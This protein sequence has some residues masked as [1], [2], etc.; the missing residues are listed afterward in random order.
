MGLKQGFNRLEKGFSRK[1]TKSE[2]ARG[3]L[4]VSNDTIV[5]GM[6]LKITINK[7]PVKKKRLDSYGR[8]GVGR[9]LMRQFGHKKVHFR[10]RD[11][12]IE[13]TY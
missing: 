6:N 9:K 10:L 11:N 5:K 8:I 1:S 3:Y 2:Q 7:E 4:F 12:K 13:I